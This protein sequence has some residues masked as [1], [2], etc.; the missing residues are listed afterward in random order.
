VAQTAMAGRMR[1]DRLPPVAATHLGLVGWCC[2]TLVNSRLS[3]EGQRDWETLET[4]GN[5]S[6]HIMFTADPGG[7]IEWVNGRGYDFTGKKGD[8]CA[9]PRQSIIHPDDL[10]RVL[11]DW[12]QARRTGVY[13]SEHRMR[14]HDGE[15]R[16]FLSR[17]WPLRGADGEVTHWFGTATDIHSQKMTEQALR[18]SELG[19]RRQLD[20]GRFP[21]GAVGK[22]DLAHLID[23]PTLQSFLDDL[24]ELTHIPV[25]IIDLEANILV[26]VGWQDICAKWHHAFQETCAHCVESDM[27]LSAGVPSGE[28]KLY[29]CKNN[30]WDMVTPLV[31]GGQHVGNIFS[32]QFFFED[33]EP[34]REVFRAQAHLY[35]FDEDEYMAALDAVPRLSRESVERGMAL[36][37]K[38]GY[39]ISQLV[40]YRARAR[41]A[42]AECDAME[43]TL[44]SLKK[45]VS[46]EVG[47]KG[48]R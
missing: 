48:A 21:Q 13:E 40:Y 10:E 31:V 11:G 23:T 34:N 39:L 35:G 9:W 28:F 20:D 16:W 45:D 24:Y 22:L 26:G 8:G 37:M 18:E 41:D 33:D 27:R 2:R 3:I 30:M 7:N 46:H 12:E 47:R 25:T 1:K 5:E 42:Q 32:G 36:L 14:R 15:Y 4:T 38:L 19:I 43:V 29:R 6:D 17:A 44:S